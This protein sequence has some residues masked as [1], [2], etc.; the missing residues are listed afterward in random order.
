MASSTSYSGLSNLQSN[1]LTANQ[2]YWRGNIYALMSGGKYI[3]WPN[4][5][6]FSNEDLINAHNEYISN[7]EN[8]AVSGLSGTTNLIT[9][10]YKHGYTFQ[11]WYTKDGTNGDWGVC[12]TE[13][14]GAS[15]LYAKWN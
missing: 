3:S 11:G 6:D 4:S 12:V 2:A 7:L 8:G 9:N 14:S 10:V 15:T 1:D 13:V 5:M